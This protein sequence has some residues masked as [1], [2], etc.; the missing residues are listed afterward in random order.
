MKALLVVDIQNDFCPGGL[1]AVKDGDKI[2]PLVNELMKNYR[3]VIATQDWHPQNHKSFASNNKGKNPGELINLNGIQQ[4]LWPDHCVQRSRGA[5]FH[6]KLDL[7][8]ITKIFRKG[9]NPE[10]DSYSAFLEN[11]QKTS[12]GLAA[13]LKEIKVNE[14]HLCGLAT[15]YCVKFSALDS[16]KAGF[17][18]KVY[19]DA[20][21][22][23]EL[24]E[25]D[26]EH[27]FEEMKNAGVEIL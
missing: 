9:A 7:A 19:K 4:I 13:Y 15:D 17:K 26:I 18:T 27:A 1:L 16:V 8:F 6:D 23:V 14:V 21:R 11:D 22:G 3:V 2:I 10:V 5:K 25:G 12:T 20:V 24:N